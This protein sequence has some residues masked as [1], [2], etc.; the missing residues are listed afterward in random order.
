M[1]ERLLVIEQVAHE[2]AGL[3]GPMAAGEGFEPAV[4]R[5]H[6]LQPLPADPREFSGILVM[7]GPMNVGDSGSHPWLEDQLKLIAS[8]A[9]RQVPV[10]GICLGSQLIAAALGA[11]VYAGEHTEIGWYG[12]RLTEEAQQDPLFGGLPREFDVFQWHGQTF[13]I[14]EGGTLL[15]GSERFAHQAFRAG[16]Y[17]WGM[18]FHL[19]VTAEHVRRWLEINAREVEREGVDAGAVLAAAGKKLSI[20]EPVARKLF[21]RFLDIC[22]QQTGGQ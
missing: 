6:E 16:K 11:R 5:M 13:E 18:Q 7:G 1:A 21:G 17:A 22:R 8:A 12:I 19:E 2:D 15:A 4:V 10:L 20:L 3:F 9:D 14:P